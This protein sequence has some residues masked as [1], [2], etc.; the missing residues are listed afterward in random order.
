MNIQLEPNLDRGIKTIAPGIEASERQLDANVT[1]LARQGDTIIAGLGNGEVVA[2]D[3]GGMSVL[4]RHE[5]AVTS[6]VSTTRGVVYSAGQDGVVYASTIG[7]AAKPIFQSGE[8]ITALAVSPDQKRLVIAVGP[9]LI[10]LEEDQIIARFVD[11]PSTVTGVRFLSDGKRLAAS[12]YNGVS[13]W[14]VEELR[15]PE[16]LKWAGSL[17]GMSVSPNDQYVV[18]ATQDRELHVWDL[19]SGRDFRLG[20]YQR[21]VK[22]FGWTQDST[23]LYTSGADV[24]V[25]WGLAGDPGAI[26][27]VEIGYAFSQTISAVAE[28]GR[29][30]RMVA[31]YTDGSVMVGEAR[32]GT[33]KIA[34]SGNGALVTAIVADAALTTF[35]FGTGD[36]RVGT[37]TLDSGADGTIGTA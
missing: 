5:G 10:V 22:A 31:G 12:R 8:W 21:K 25:A 37:I 36:G 35:A 26:P 11:H 24:L 13:I 19:V 9:R 4:A 28:T 14:S 32:K 3:N 7:G 1:C 18:A 17:T 33:A 23:Y 34:R 2:L 29:P 15:K 27:P 20:G 30:D 6:A 16:D